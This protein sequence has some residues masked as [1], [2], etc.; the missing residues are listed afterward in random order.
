MVEATVNEQ[1]NVEPAFAALRQV[2]LW[3][4]MSKT[5]HSVEAH[6]YPIVI[7]Q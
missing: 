2:G 6:N 4:L 5:N 3:F 1:K 7:H